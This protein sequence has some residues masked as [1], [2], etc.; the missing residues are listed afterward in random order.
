MLKA[1]NRLSFSGA[2]PSRGAPMRPTENDRSQLRY[3]SDLTDEEWALIEPMIP[4]AKRDG[5]GYDNRVGLV[6]INEHNSRNG[7]RLNIPQSAQSQAQSLL[8]A[9]QAIESRWHEY[10]FVI[11]PFRC[12]VFYLKL[13]RPETY[14]SRASSFVKSEHEYVSL[15][16]ARDTPCRSGHISSH[17]GVLASSIRPRSEETK[18]HLY[19]G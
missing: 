10:Q 5:I 3:S 4:P 7:Y 12:F 9:S 2:D 1:L 17:G 8:R 19:H 15:I 11:G 16:H 14:E 6:S 18:H 13:P